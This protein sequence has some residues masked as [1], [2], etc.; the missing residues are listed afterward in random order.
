M[1]QQEVQLFL[2]VSTNCTPDSHSGSKGV[3]PEFAIQHGMSDSFGPVGFASAKPL[4]LELIQSTVS[5]IVQQAGSLGGTQWLAT[6]VVAEATV[7]AAGSTYPD[8][9]C[10]TSS[11][12]G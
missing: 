12:R 4:L 6:A 1:G 8:R 10:R 2:Y 3:R 9:C 5:C 7:V 11:S